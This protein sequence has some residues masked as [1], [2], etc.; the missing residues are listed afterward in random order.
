[1][2]NF[3]K[4]YNKTKI[5][6]NLSNENDGTKIY[7]P[8]IPLDQKIN[9]WEIFFMYYKDMYCK[10]HEIDNQKFQNV[11]WYTTS[12]IYHSSL[13]TQKSSIQK[14]QLIKNIQK[15]KIFLENIWVKVSHDPKFLAMTEK[16]NHYTREV[17]A[18]FF[19]NKKLNYS[20]NTVNRSKSYQT[21]I[22]SSN[23]VKRE[24]EIPEYTIKY[25]IGTKWQ[26][27]N[28]VTDRIETIFADVA[29]A[30]NPVDKRYKKLIGQNVL[31]PIINKNIPIIWDESV[32]VFCG[33]WAIRVTPW[34]DEFWLE[35]AKKHGL[36]TDVFAIDIDW[37]FTEHAWEFAWKDLSEFFD[38]IIK[39]VDDIW[40]L[41]SQR[42]VKGYRYFH[43]STNEELFPMSIKQRSL[44]Y[45]YSKDY[46]LNYIQEKNIDIPEDIEP[47]YNQIEQKTNFWIS[48]R[49][50]NGLLIPIVSNNSWEEFLLDDETIINIYDNTRTRK[51]IVLTIIIINLILDNNLP[52]IFTLQDLIQ[53][54]FSRNV[55]WDKTKLQEYIDIYSEIW[56][57]NSLYKNWLKSLNKLIDGVEKNAEKVDYLVELLQDSFAIQMDNDDISV[58]YH[59]LFKVWWLS[60][61][62]ED[63]FNKSFI[64]ACRFLHNLWC[65][66]SSLSYTEIEP[67]NNFFMTTKEDETVLLDMCLLAL[68][69]SKRN[70][71]PNFIYT[72]VLIDQKGDKVT[73]YNSKFLNKDLY[74]NL[75][76][77]GLDAMRLTLLLWENKNDDPNIVIFDTYKAN[78]Y[79]LL[80]D[81]IWNANRYIFGK[82]KEKYNNWPI[83]IKEV[84]SQIQEWWITEY[85]NWMLHNMKMI[86]EDYKYQVS[87]N[88]YLSFWKKLIENYAQ[89]FCDK[90][91]NI[92]KIINNEETKWIMLLIWIIFLDLCY[93]F[94]PNIISEIKSKFNIDY[95][96]INILNLNDLELKE[97][98]YKINIFSEV[99][100]KINQMKKKIWLKK[101]EVADVFVQANPDFLNFLHDNESI[102]RLLTK[103]QSVNLLRSNEDM[104]K[105]CEV[106]NVI[107]ILVWVKKP[108]IVAV[109]IKKDVLVD[110]ETEYRE[111]TDHL[112]HLKALF[113]SIY[114][115]ADD[116]L[117]EKKR[118]EI[119]NLQE[120]IEDLEFKIGKLKINS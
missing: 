27:I 52:E 32:D 4:K 115:N 102:F 118:Q 76:T 10:I 61:Q 88:K 7:S 16:F 59:D 104:P 95:Q 85:D 108:D 77:Y 89:L 103:I 40:N 105:W 119:S 74:E 98:N 44:P 66:Y 47:M 100:D 83:R 36:P 86:L 116:D 113:A 91:V 65:E 107:N 57:E 46:L 117:V 39:Y 75:N 78:E 3:P 23:V 60:L 71:F 9:P 73:N 56:Q 18:K 94:I 5:I 29:I 84:L 82:Y 26:A 81:K 90:Y 70:I 67:E 120:E 19:A 68:Q 63:S 21:Y 35:L 45:D 41:E 8:N 99:V 87:E 51:S 12:S 109:E 112:Q 11:T 15:N 17:F 37:K 28:V 96:W 48:N 30:V 106:D 33:E 69:Y 111:K 13:D 97:K 72:P 20:Q 49:S 110:L 54:L 22:D 2:E 43:K 55:T 31:I 80:L 62:K 92:T 34:H 50:S 101:H 6:K 93:P 38:N 53:A 14:V 114:W 24:V 58:N 64:D 25:F 79:S 1:M 42:I